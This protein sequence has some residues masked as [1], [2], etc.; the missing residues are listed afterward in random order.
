MD[1]EEEMEMETAKIINLK[2][3][4]KILIMGLK[5]LADEATD[6]SIMRTVGGLEYYAKAFEKV[7]REMVKEGFNF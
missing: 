7:Y 3:E 2:L 1:K 5:K 6:T 4:K